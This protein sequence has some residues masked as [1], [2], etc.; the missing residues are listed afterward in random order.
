LHAYQ[1]GFMHPVT[2]QAMRFSAPV[3]QDLRNALNAWGVGY[4]PPNG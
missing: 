1:L 4:N 3:P 2:G